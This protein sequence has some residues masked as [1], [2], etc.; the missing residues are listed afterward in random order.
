MITDLYR[1][2]DADGRLLYVGVSFHAVVR[3]YQH[4]AGAEWW[5]QA[6]TMKVE[7]FPTRE[8]ALLAER[9]AI[10]QEKPLHNQVHTVIKKPKVIVPPT[11]NKRPLNSQLIKSLKPRDNK[12][13]LVWDTV[14]R[15]LAVQVRPTGSK[16]WKVVYTAYGRVRWYTLGPADIIGLA[17]ARVKASKILIQVFEGGDPA[18]DK[19]QERKKHISQRRTA[20]NHPKENP[21]V[22]AGLLLESSQC[23]KILAHKQ[24]PRK[25]TGA[26]PRNF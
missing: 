6:V 23:L 10:K 3:A 17:D 8:A 4:K 24:M 14:Q 22:A 26:K 2:F 12:T 21:A 7:R 16:S 18:T 19:Q 5:A 1:H 9:E 13:Y 15:G 11:K 25:L 20:M